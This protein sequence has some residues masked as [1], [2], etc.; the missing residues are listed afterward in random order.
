MKYCFDPDLE[1]QTKAIQAAA[2]LRRGAPPLDRG[3]SL[4]SENG[5]VGNR[6]ALSDAALLANLRA[7]QQD[8]ELYNSRPISSARRSSPS[9]ARR[10]CEL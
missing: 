1:Y 6:L 3:F 4:I 2:C 5:V 7:V 10:E 8:P 9:G